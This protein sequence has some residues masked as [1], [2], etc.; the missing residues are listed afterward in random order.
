MSPF[1]SFFLLVVYCN[2]IYSLCYQLIKL[3]FLA[4]LY[5]FF[6]CYLQSP[7]LW[8]STLTKLFL[9]VWFY[10]ILCLLQEIKEPGHTCTCIKTLFLPESVP[11]CLPNLLYLTT[12]LAVLVNCLLACIE[13]KGYIITHRGLTNNS[14]SLNSAK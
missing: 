4:L 13:Y 8:N 6:T 5:L 7:C 3:I 11:F 14:L 10:F 1:Y 12:C 9:F 2:N